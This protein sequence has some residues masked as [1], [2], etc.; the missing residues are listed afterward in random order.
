M[1]LAAIHT[2]ALCIVA[3]CDTHVY[4]CTIT[5]YRTGGAPASSSLW[6][7]VTWDGTKFSSGFDEC[8]EGEKQ[9]E[10]SEQAHYLRSC[11]GAKQRSTVA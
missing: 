10:V 3:T 6:N 1:G 4:K 11:S 7:D 2:R 8:K 5:M 9:S